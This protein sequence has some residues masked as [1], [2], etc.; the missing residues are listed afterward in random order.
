[1]DQ[2]KEINDY[3]MNKKSSKNFEIVKMLNELGVLKYKPMDLQYYILR[4]M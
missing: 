4:P 1:M 2:F 3:I